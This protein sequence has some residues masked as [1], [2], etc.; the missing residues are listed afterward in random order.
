MK[1]RTSTNVGEPIEV[2][3]DNE[4]VHYLLGEL[5]KILATTTQVVVHDIA[6]DALSACGVEGLEPLTVVEINSAHS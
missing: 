5:R 6:Y 4:T 1:D 2:D 3:T